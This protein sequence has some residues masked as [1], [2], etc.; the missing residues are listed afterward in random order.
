MSNFGY[1]NARVRAWKSYLFDKAFFEKLMNTEDVAGVSAMLSQTDYQV[2]IEKGIMKYKGVSG[3]EEG[4]RINVTKTLKKLL[5]IIRG[6]KEGENLLKVI[7]SRWDIY[8][9]KTILRGFHAEAT[10]EQ[11]FEQLIPVGVLDEAALQTLTKQPGMKAAIDQL[12]VF[13]PEYVKPLRDG[14]KEYKESKNLAGLELKLDK[15]YFEI[16]IKQTSKRSTNARLLNEVIRREIDFVNLMTLLRLTNEQLPA[17]YN[18][19][20]FFIKGGK[21][22][23]V[24][25]LVQLAAIKNVKDTIEALARTS[26]YSCLKKGLQKYNINRSLASIER[27]LEDFNTRKT[28]SLFRAD[29]LSIAT[30]VAYIW[31]KINEIINIRIILRGKEV[32]MPANEI[33]EAVVF[34]F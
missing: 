4:L 27:S 18:F 16:I 13:S 1:P 9:L 34:A 21:E 31:A 22:L 8:N 25:R 30:I 12:I 11:I 28:I 10:E 33:K 2:D 6:N 26:Y 32:Q 3:I 15:F 7:L 23:T 24:E 14:F 17:D 5:K 29:P 20:T 19:D